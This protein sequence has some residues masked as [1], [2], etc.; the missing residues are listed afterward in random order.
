MGGGTG[1]AIGWIQAG[2]SELG[3]D[4]K[5]G[6]GKLAGLSLGKLKREWTEKREDRKIEKGTA[7]GSDAGRLEEG[8]VLEMLL[9]KWNKMNDMVSPAHNLRW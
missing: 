7:W 9:E 5:V 2:M 4:V 6:E 3:L 1:Q 8:R